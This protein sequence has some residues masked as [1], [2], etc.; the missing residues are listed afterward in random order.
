VLPVLRVVHPDLRAV[1]ALTREPHGTVDR[2]RFRVLHMAEQR[3]AAF[4]PVQP[5]LLDLTT[6]LEQRMDEFLVGVAGKASNPDGSTIP[7][8]LRLRER[9]IL[10]NSIRGKG[11]CPPRSR[12]ERAHL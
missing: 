10:A 5:D 8:F 7:R 6:P 12:D 9:P 2:R 1:E 4:T 3:A 11:A